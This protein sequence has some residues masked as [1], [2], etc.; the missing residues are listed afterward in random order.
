MTRFRTAFR[1]AAALGFV[2]GLRS[3]LSGRSP[4]P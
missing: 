1:L 4:A 3:A 2:L